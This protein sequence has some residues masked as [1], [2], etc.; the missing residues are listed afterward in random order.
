[1]KKQALI[2]TT[3]GL[4]IALVLLASTA[5]AQV[6]STEKIGNTSRLSGTPVPNNPPS[7]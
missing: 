5:A 2:G 6:G 7:P 1:M 4:M 3:A